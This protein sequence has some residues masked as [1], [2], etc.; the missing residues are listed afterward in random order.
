[1]TYLFSLRA[2]GEIL[3]WCFFVWPWTKWGQGQWVRSESLG[4]SVM[5]KM[6]WEMKTRWRWE[7]DSV[8]NQECKFLE[9]CWKISHIHFLRVFT[10]VHH[11]NSFISHKC[12]IHVS[13]NWINIASGNGFWPVQRQAITWTNAD[14]LSIGP[15]GTNFGEVQIKI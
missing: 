10:R 7:L 14:L 11:I 1:M 2:P 9:L 8:H 13:V 3:C 5:L 6:K 4:L 12:H 15:L